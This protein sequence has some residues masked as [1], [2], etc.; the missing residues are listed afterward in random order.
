MFD[1]FRLRNS[2]PNKEKIE[3]LQKLNDFVNE[4]IVENVDDTHCEYSL[5]PFRIFIKLWLKN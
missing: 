2:S 4:F 5:S 1:P 3:D